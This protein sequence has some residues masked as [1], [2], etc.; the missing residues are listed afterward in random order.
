MKVEKHSF[1]PRK[2]KRNLRQWGQQQRKIFYQRKRE[3]VGREETREHSVKEVYDMDA[4][5]QTEMGWHIV[6]IKTLKAETGNFVLDSSLHRKPVKC[7]E[8]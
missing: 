5:D 2:R 1:V 8:R 3:I 6:G 4:E 7:S